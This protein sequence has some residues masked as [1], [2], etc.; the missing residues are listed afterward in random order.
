MTK[1]LQ[2]VLQLLKILTT[3]DPMANLV[4]KRLDADLELQCAGRK[5]DDYF[6][7]DGRQP[8]G[9]HFKMIEKPGLPAFEAE[10]EQ[11]PA[12][13]DVQ[14]ESAIHELELLDPALQ[15]PLQVAEECRKR[16]LP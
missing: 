3:A 5:S 13:I 10:F 6:P 15:E 9:D 2:I 16:G 1:K 14:I 12:G 11:C 4:I 8:I 7:K